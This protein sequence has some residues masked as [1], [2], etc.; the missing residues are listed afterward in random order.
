M[1]GTNIVMP[2]LL[3]ERYSKPRIMTLWGR[4][5]TRTP[6]VI[7]AKIGDGLQVI[8]LQPMMTRPNYYVIFV[9]S[10][11]EME[12]DEW[13][14]HLEE[15]YSTIEDQCGSDTNYEIGKD[16]QKKFTNNPWPALSS[17]GCTWWRIK[18][19]ARL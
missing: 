11:W 9:D 13:I 12:T 19:L 1:T 2:S 16:G 8:A 7:K 6:E 3:A 18:M 15:I 4:E 17:D 14:N 5:Y 10:R